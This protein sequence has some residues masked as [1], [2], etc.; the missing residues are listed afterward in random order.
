MI[1]KNLFVTQNCN[2]CKIIKVTAMNL[3][4]AQ[5]KRGKTGPCKM[6]KGDFRFTFSNNN[7]FIL[8]THSNVAA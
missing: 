2:E 7:N 3:G 1:D 6:L 5:Y 8:V 4:Q